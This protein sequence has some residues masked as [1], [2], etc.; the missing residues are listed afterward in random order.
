MYSKR[1]FLSAVSLFMVL[2]VLNMGLGLRVYAESETNKHYTGEEI[3]S[4]VFFGQGEVAKLFPEMWEQYQATINNNSQEFEQIKNNVIAEIKE[5][6]SDFFTNFGTEM[7]SGDHLRVQTAL[8]GGAQ[9]IRQ[10]K[11]SEFNQ[12]FVKSAYNV[13]SE[14]EVTVYVDIAVAVAVVAVVFLVITVIDFTPVAPGG[15]AINSPSTLQR[16]QLVDMLTVK[17]DNAA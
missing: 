9:E 7:R 11:N 4:G 3:F 13:S 5:K 6:D 12:E 17:L 10:L 1:T 2:T 16:D 15:Q 14:R 8:Q